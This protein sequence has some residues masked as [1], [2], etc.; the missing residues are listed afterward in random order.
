[1]RTTTIFLML[2]FGCIIFVQPLLAQDDGYFL[3]SDKK[4][5]LDMTLEDLLN[6]KITTASQEEETMREAPVPVTIIT[7]KMIVN[8]GA[9][10]LR[11]LLAI[12]VPGMSV[13][14]DHNEMN[15]AM[16]GVYASSQQKILVMLNGHRMNSRSYSEAN[17]DYAMSLEKV[18][19]IEILRGPASS[20]YGNVALTAVINVITKTGSEQNGLT[21]EVGA[22][23][24]G[25]RKV[26]ILY[27]DSISEKKDFLVW[28]KYYKADGE[29]IAISKEED[30]SAN[31]NAGYAI[32]DGVKDLPSYDAGFNYKSNKFNFLG[33]SSY[34]KYIEP[35]TAGGATGE[36]YNYNDYR[37]FLGTGPGLAN[38]SSGL[39]AKYDTDLG[40]DFSLSVNGY[41]DL[42]TIQVALVA[43][44]N[45]DTSKPV[46]QSFGSP[47]W[48]EV[49][50][51]ITAQLTK[52]YETDTWGRGSI[53]LG[54]NI[55][56][57]EVVGSIYP[58]GTNGEFTTIN[59]NSAVPVLDEG[60]ETIYSVF[61]QI[62]HYINDYWIV[63]VG[64]RYDDKDRHQGVNVTNFS[65]RLSLV[66]LMNDN[67]DFKLSY[68]NAFV[69]APY[70]YRYNSLASYKGS[71]ELKPELLSSIQFTPTFFFLNKTLSNTTNVYYNN[72]RDLIYRNPDPNATVK[73]SN[74]GSLES[75]GVEDEISYAHR[76]FK[77]KAVLTYQ[78]AIEA[79]N[80]GITD[81]KI[82]NIPSLTANLIFDINPFYNYYKN[83][84]FNI[85]YRYI[86]E[87]AS[88]IAP[89]TYLGGNQLTLGVPDNMVSSTSLFNTGFRVD[90][91]KGL[92]FDARVYN[93]FNTQ[94][95]QGGTTKMPYPQ[96]G[97]WYL[98][99]LGY[100]FN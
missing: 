55:D 93:V 47:M 73:Y 71:S 35:F 100:T 81:K 79:E 21:V 84:S 29:S 11:D 64:G 5:L 17:P 65:P 9:K 48:Y 37:K 4:N 88:P 50:E 39:D 94:N 82:N 80:Y 6:I 22:G 53:L 28:L 66:Y 13:V 99:T 60:K 27:G 87:Q 10:N 68:S 25:Q 1:M 32:V 54:S 41:V 8:S 86:G 59:D 98:I 23:N 89:G 45:T 92:S 70:W 78:Q 83:F 33:Y 3:T 12:Y 31:P 34:T 51:G 20:L 76:F 49:S 44:P 15:I 95:S 46:V 96:A 57:M 14:Q 18:M 62:K 69:D 90:K 61:A 26:S 43:N 2:F 30:Y 19:Q 7:S 38:L 74:A 75:W 24:Y 63:N 85:T 97:R 40:S 52:K 56:R 77:T 67:I 91:I 36:V 58:A 72:V 42:N 16:R